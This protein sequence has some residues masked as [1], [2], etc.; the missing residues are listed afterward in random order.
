MGA[1]GPGGAVPWGL[2]CLRW[3]PGARPGSS[4]GGGFGPMSATQKWLCPPW[5]RIKIHVDFDID[6][7]SFW[8]RSWAPLGGYFQSF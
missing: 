5:I 7:W 1:W 2:G 6:F 3:L 8:G 4:P